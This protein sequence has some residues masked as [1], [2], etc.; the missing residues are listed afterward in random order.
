MQ[1]TAL[2]YDDIQLVPEYSSVKHRKDIRLWTKVSRNFT[3]GIPLV[4]SPMSTVCGKEMA[5]AFAHAGGVG[6]IHRF[7]SIEEEAK[8]V[9]DLIYSLKVSSWAPFTEKTPIMAAI[10]AN[11]DYLE[12]AQELIKA[13][14]NILLMDV[15]HGHHEN[16]KLA[17][18]ELRK[19]SGK[20]DIIAGNIATRRAAQDLCEWGVD[21]LRVG[22]GGGSLCTTRIKTGFGIPNVTSLEDVLSFA[23]DSCSP[24]I[25]VMADGGI[26]SSGD[27]AKALALGASTVMLGSLIAGC[28]EAPGNLYTNEKGVLCKR[29]SGSASMETKGAS[30]LPLRNIEGVSKGIPYKGFVHHILEDLVDGIKSALSYGGAENLEQFHPD[31]VVITNAGMAE[32]QPHL[33]G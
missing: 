10:G 32:A 26:R 29:Y 6:C 13:G 16:V 1:K 9:K 22:I 30:G 18:E 4:A 33:L 20:F 14:A 19:L 5:Y 12:C 24:Q 27:I 31:Y 2:T 11:G 28:E 25:P 21:G 23:R 17:I 15:A 8:S 3:I 7:S